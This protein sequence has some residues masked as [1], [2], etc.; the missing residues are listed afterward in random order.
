MH[1]LGRMHKAIVQ[2][3]AR[4]IENVEGLAAFLRATALYKH[5]KALSET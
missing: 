3:A 1:C 4:Y 2:D 5:S